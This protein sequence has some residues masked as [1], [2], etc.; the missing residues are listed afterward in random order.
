VLSTQNVETAVHRS[1]PAP[2]GLR[3]RLERW[4]ELWRLDA[5]E[6]GLR[7]RSR[8]GVVVVSRE[9][10]T[11][12]GREDALVVE[13]GT[14]IPHEVAVRPAHGRV[15]FVGSMTWAPN[16][17]AV[18]WW[19]REVRP[20][21]PAGFPALS[22]VGRG[23]D[24]VFAGT[25]GLEVLGEVPEMAAVM[26]ETRAVVVPLQHGGG[27][28]LKVLEALAW[29]RPVVSTTKGVEGLRVVDGEHV[30][31]ADDGAAFARRVEEVCRDDV[32]AERLTRAGRSLASSYSWDVIGERYAEGLLGEQS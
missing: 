23:G 11:A 28:R 30:L 21:L 17:E 22:V 8:A 12:L 31:V 3:A 7:S 13:N 27:T 32:L 4:W 2:S 24:E 20:H 10:A 26:R 25:P 16:V 14:D 9:D 18:R 29:E 6:R 5:L 19:L 15:L 1:L